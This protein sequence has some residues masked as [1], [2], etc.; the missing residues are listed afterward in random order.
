MAS[1]D[2]RRGGDGGDVGV[3]FQP[4]LDTLKQE[5]QQ[6]DPTVLSVLAAL[7]VVLLTLGKATSGVSG[8]SG[9]VGFRP[10]LLCADLEGEREGGE[11]KRREEKRDSPLALR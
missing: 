7:L 3:A 5:L 6:G 10:G 4:Y 2:Y 11:E 9:Q 1:A 8:G